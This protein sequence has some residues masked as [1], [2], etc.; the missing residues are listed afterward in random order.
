MCA[1]IIKYAM[2]MRPQSELDKKM[3]LVYARPVL[4]GRAENK[5][6]IKELSD[7]TTLTATD[8][9]AVLTGLRERLVYHLRN[10]ELVTLNGIGSFRVRIKSQ[11]AADSDGHVK[12]ED[13]HVSGVQ[14]KPSQEFLSK[15]QD[16]DFKLTAGTSI[17]MPSDKEISL[18]L[19]EHFSR[20]SYITT[21]DIM[22][23]FRLSRRRSLQIAAQLVERG[24]LVRNGKGSTTHYVLAVNAS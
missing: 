2:Q 20:T 5:D 13:L 12:M 17:N 11:Q 6:I 21:S 4:S 15:V 18:K 9:E 19:D 14:F 8:I 16:V 10:G 24:I 22:R 3:R 1:K 23:A 7:S